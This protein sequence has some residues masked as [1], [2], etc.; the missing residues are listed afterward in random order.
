VKFRSDH[1]SSRETTGRAAFLQMLVDEG[2]T[3]LFG[4]PGTTDLPIMEVVP[5]FPRLQFVLALRE[6]LV[7]AMADGFRR[8][9][10]PLSAAN[11]HVAPGLGNAMG[12]LHNARS[13]A[14]R[15]F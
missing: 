5:D 2:V 6:A 8:A 4:N 9:S 1:V 13:R 15:S 3:Y 14:R 11:V 12:A 10:G 7:A